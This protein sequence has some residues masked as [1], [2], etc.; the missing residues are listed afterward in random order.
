[1]NL[2]YAIAAPRPKIKTNINKAKDL[3]CFIASF[4][5]AVC[6]MAALAI[7]GAFTIRRYCGE[8]RGC[9]GVLS[10]CSG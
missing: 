1:L 10:P 2:A 6:F 7:A 8:Q 3:F 4:S 5:G 9:Y